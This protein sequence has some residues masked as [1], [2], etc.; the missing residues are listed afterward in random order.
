MWEVPVRRD[1]LH[2]SRRSPHPLALSFAAGQSPKKEPRPR[3]CGRGPP[4]K[5]ETSAKAKFLLPLRIVDA[6]APGGIA[7]KQHFFSRPMPRKLMRRT[8]QA[9]LVVGAIW[10]TAAMF[11]DGFRRLPGRD[12]LREAARPRWIT[13]R[14][15]TGA[16]QVDRFSITPLGSQWM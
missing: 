1:H 16:F 14:E 11:T 12:R 15:T 10:L 4:Q 9:L 7:T 8:G 5:E 3:G 13:Y 6:N 2:I